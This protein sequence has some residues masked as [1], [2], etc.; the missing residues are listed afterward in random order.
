[1]DADK[2]VPEEKEKDL[3]SVGTAM[4]ATRHIRRGCEP[5]TLDDILCANHMLEGGGSKMCSRELY[6]C[7]YS[8][9][10]KRILLRCEILLHNPNVPLTQ[11]IVQ[12][13]QERQ[14]KVVLHRL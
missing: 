3:M 7:F 5:N 11:T 4:T 12:D 9:N 13:E 6:T 14:T 10:H 2:E 8:G 1:M